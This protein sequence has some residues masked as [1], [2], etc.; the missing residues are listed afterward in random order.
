MSGKGTKEQSYT[1]HQRAMIQTIIET[2]DWRE[3]GIVLK[4][5]LDGEK[6][7]Q[8]GTSLVK[9]ALQKI[10]EATKNGQGEEDA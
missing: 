8:L 9:A 2:S 5:R 3:V 1:M 10:K 4:E 6:L 7:L